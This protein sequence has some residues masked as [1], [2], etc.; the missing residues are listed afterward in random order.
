MK[1][2]L[3]NKNILFISLILVIGLVVTY[4]VRKS[5]A[6]P[7]ENDV[8]VEEY[9]ELTYYL[10][11]S[12]DGVDQ[13]GIE[14]SDTLTSNVI[15][16]TLYVTDKIP[17]GLKFLGFVTTEDGTIGS[18]KRSDNTYCPGHV[19]DD[20]RDGPADDGVWND[21][22]TE[23]NYHGLHYNEN[24][25]TVTFT[26]KGLQAGCMLT[27]G[28]K[29]M[30]QNVDDFNTP[31]VEKRR[32]F[33]NFFIAKENDYIVNSNT[34][35]AFIGD[36]E[37]PLHNVDYEYTGD[38][39]PVA[40]KTP[41]KSSYAKSAKVGVAPSV[42]VPGYEFSGWSTDDVSVDNN[43][44]VMPDSDVTLR[45]SFEELPKY[46]VIYAID[47]DKPSNYVLPT[48]KE[49]NKDDVVN[50]DSLKVGDEINGY[51]FLGWTTNDVTITSDNNF[52]MPENNITITGRFEEIKYKVTYAFFDTVTPPNADSLLPEVK[53]Y[54]PG[55][56]VT[57]PTV[58]NVTGY[59]FLGW[60]KE[61]NFV[62]PEE[63]VTVYGEWMVQNGT[64]ELTIKK[65]IVDKKD[66]YEA[67]ETVNYKITV[68][69]PETFEI[70]DIV[71]KEDNDRAQFVKGT[72]YELQTAHLAKIT[73]LSAGESIALNASYTVREDEIDKVDNKVLIVGARAS[74][75][76]IIVD[77]EISS[78]SEFIIK[79]KLVVHHYIEGTT[80]KV[81]EDEIT[82]YKYGDKYV[83]APLKTS[84]LA[85]EYKNAYHINN[86][87][88]PITM[89]TM[90][91]NLVEVTYYYSINKY[92][93]KVSVTGGV[94]TITGNEEVIHGNNSKEN[95]IIIKP[96]T[97]YEISKVLV[98]GIE[99][100][101]TNNLGMTLENFKNVVNDHIVE[102][103]FKELKA[104]APITGKYV[105]YIAIASILFVL[106]SGA[107][108]IY[109]KS[110]KR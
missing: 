24:T 54:K 53:Y 7:L 68:T 110:L 70:R 95:N 64:F 32:D 73:K 82:S 39:P 98:D 50:L 43:S 38:V 87:L 76:Y 1:K 94:G 9:S 79:T 60:Y 99:I 36:E 44:F 5:F 52:V 89:G 28:I 27:V 77:K 25:R 49:Y 30:T 83:T 105:S 65:E 19:V 40:P 31:E 63:D 4:F 11:I 97:G 17:E 14:S 67:G 51:R 10:N 37:E 66:S 96:E 6:V 8:R 80:T 106:A 34:V 61:D 23:Y 102:V 46:Q 92:N 29:T 88:F 93:I 18:V 3:K 86:S 41:L 2:I 26:V 22:Q 104:P 109:R 12:Y 100:N 103:E 56:K 47:G 71:V 69:N 101:I 90:D 78:T 107:F 85:G 20:N 58:N 42:D 62:M 81:H 72:G 16:D 15:G 57:H 13:S 55:E 45:G 33:Y 35:H 75:N 91:K 59:K 48:T 74:D 108:V 84:E 21:N